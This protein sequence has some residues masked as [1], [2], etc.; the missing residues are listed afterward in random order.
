MT[1]NFKGLINNETL[2]NV[3]A[4][5][6]KLMSSLPPSPAGSYQL[7]ISAQDG[8]DSPALVPANVSIVVVRDSAQA[9]LFTSAIYQFS[10]AENSGEDQP[11]GTVQALVQGIVAGWAQN[12]WSSVSVKP[13][14]LQITLSLL[15]AVGRRK[16]AKIII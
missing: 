10:V 12:L 4:G 9:P 8:L 7:T 16:Y 5:E 15:Q 13:Q 1:Q 11:V 14:S 3:I 2:L 6:V